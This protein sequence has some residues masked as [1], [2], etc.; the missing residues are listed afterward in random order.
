MRARR[1]GD[2]GSLD[3]LL[4]TMTNVVGILVI[5]LVVTQ[6]G[7]RD[8]VSRISQSEAVSPEALAEAESQLDALNQQR[9]SL[10]KQVAMIGSDETSVGWLELTREVA[11]ARRHAEALRKESIE[12]EARIKQ[13]LA[14]A[15]ERAAQSKARIDQ[16]EKEAVDLE[17]QLGKAEQRLAQLRAQLAITP[18]LGALPSKVVTIPNPRAA[19]EGAAAV[20]YL[21]LADRLVP[22]DLEELRDRAQKRAKYIVGRYRLDRDKAKGIDGELLTKHFN[23]EKIRTDDFELEMTISGNRYPVLLLH[24]R[25]DAG[26]TVEALRG[27]TSRFERLA[28]RADSQKH[29]L[30]FLVWPDSFETYLVAREIATKR[31]L[32]AGWAPKSPP[33]VHRVSLGGPLRVGPPPPPKPKP[34]EPAPNPT[35]KPKPKPVDEID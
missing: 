10:R 27:K 24:P 21:C 34:T 7:V 11:A 25:K 4:D 1:R 31:N 19:P 14:E 9:V 22:V 16:L 8:A 17:Q 30:R 32:L 23:K 6:L 18:Q 13:M 15:R 5:L 20:E 33:D 28:A 35:P 3:S 26:E 29:Y 12:S 2:I